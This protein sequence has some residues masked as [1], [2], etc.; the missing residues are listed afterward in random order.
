MTQYR[1][2]KKVSLRDT[3]CTKIIYFSVLQSWC[4]ELFEDICES[5]GILPNFEVQFPI[6]HVECDYIM[7]LSWRDSCTVSLE[8]AKWNRTSFEL[9]YLVSRNAK[10]VFTARFTHVYL[11][12]NNPSSVDG[13]KENIFV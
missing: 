4:I 3:D 10:K 9:K 13:I 5:T 1:Q 2:V 6:V 7:P 8:S 12:K 11:L